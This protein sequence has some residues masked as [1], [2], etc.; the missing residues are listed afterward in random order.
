MSLHE[1]NGRTIITDFWAKPIP[2]R[3]FDWSA[4]VDGTEES[5]QIGHGATEQ[6]AIDDLLMIVDDGSDD[7]N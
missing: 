4:W 1:I 2:P 6:A 7:G 3:Q 5:G